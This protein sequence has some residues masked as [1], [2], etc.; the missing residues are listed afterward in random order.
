[1]TVGE[2][3]SKFITDELATEQTKKSSL[4]ARGISIITTSGTLVTLLFALAAVVTKATN[5]K[6]PPSAAWV[7]IV[8]GVLFVLAAA[9]GMFANSPIPYNR[10]EPSSLTELVDVAEWPQDGAE[11]DRQLTHARLEELTDA[12]ARNEFKAW[13]VV[14]GLSAEVLAL[15][16]TLVAIA[17]VLAYR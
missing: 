10:V 4:E 7:L 1:M 11:A 14:F 5:Y 8:A 15:V 16:L 2:V 3:A 6:L 17:V 12:R 9:F 13:L